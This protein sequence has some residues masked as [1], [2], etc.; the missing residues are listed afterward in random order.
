MKRRWH[1]P[2]YLMIKPRPL[3]RTAMIRLC[4]ALGIEISYAPERWHSTLLPIGESTASMI[5]AIHRALKAF[6]AEPFPIVFD[7]IEGDTLKPRRGQRAPGHFQ[8]AL[9]AYIARYYRTMRSA[10]TST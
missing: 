5:E 7:H 8:R 2:L 10:C 9:T 6:D 1:K 4:A 3:E